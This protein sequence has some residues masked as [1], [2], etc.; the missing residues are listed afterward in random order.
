M[1]LSDRSDCSPS[2]GHFRALS[3]A[4]SSAMVERIRH[5]CVS[6]A[7]SVSLHSSYVPYLP[8]RGP[9]W[10]CHGV[11]APQPCCPVFLFLLLPCFTL[12]KVLFGIHYTQPRRPHTHTPAG[13]FLRCLTFLLFD[14]KKVYNL[15]SSLFSFLF[16]TVLL[17][18]P[19]VS[20]A[21]RSSSKTYGPAPPRNVSST[22]QQPLH[23]PSGRTSP[24]VPDG[25]FGRS[26][27]QNP[28]LW[29]C[30]P[31]FTAQ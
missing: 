4:D 17:A 14:E 16:A 18:S 29:A 13:L 27:G 30:T 31:N 11:A 1:L 9:Y 20:I 15:F 24:S 22:T 19:F 21:D 7:S 8:L 5:A 28:N 12:P 2:I 26:A 25:P 3:P 23:N 10:R 6:I